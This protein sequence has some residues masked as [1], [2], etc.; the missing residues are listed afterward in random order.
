M[1]VLPLTEA[2]A[3]RFLERRRRPDTVA[4]MAARRIVADVRRRG[5]VALAA[6]TRR[7]D[8]QQAARARLRVTMPELARAERETGAAFRRS[9]QRA[10]R[11]IR[12]VA[13]RQLPRSW[14]LRVE[15]GVR[16]GQIVRPLTA[17]GCYVPGGRYPLVSSLLM[18]VLPAQVAGVRRIVVACPRPSGELLAAARTLGVSEVLRVGGAQAIGALAYGTE[19]IGPV[20]KIVGPGNRWVAAAK[21]LVST[22]VAVD[23][24]AGPT[25][26][27]VLA[28]RGD[29][30]FI[31]ADLVAQAEH[32]PDAVALLVTTSRS[33]AGRVEAEVRQQLAA[34]PADNPARR[35]IASRGAVLVA[36]SLRDAISFASRFAPE[37]LSLPG[38]RPL[39]ARLD[40]A[41]SV[42]LG[43][44]SAQSAGDFATGSNHS[45]PTGGT[46][47]FRGGLGAADFVRCISVQEV[48]RA[49]LRRLA[50]VVR[51]FA[52]AEGLAA[53]A[54]AVEVRL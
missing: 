2:V 7:L 32:D 28:T 42:F 9:L 33:L 10:A 43:P 37:H 53:H 39:L 40:A 26:V 5:D 51:A 1:R 31:A 38:G 17:V 4:D 30:R 3:R 29:A 22:D 47:R 25:E 18:T 35:S 14:S 8:G 15:P 49:G 21:R 48:S 50:P 13:R 52:A 41:G 20:E 16:V 34:L 12:R 46:A 19:T 6:W 54:R 11:N 24:V 45:L 36:A 44:F 23:M 27:L